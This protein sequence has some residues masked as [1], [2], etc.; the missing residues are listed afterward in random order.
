MGLGSF[1]ELLLTK[2]PLSLSNSAPSQPRLR[3]FMQS[4]WNH[5][6]AHSFL[7]IRSEVLII[8]TAKSDSQFERFTT[9]MLTG[10]ISTRPC[11]ASLLDHASPLALTASKPLLLRLLLLALYDAQKQE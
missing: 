7:F 6:A 4:S 3:I 5:F 1:L 10:P 8:W 11:S 2:I 9:V